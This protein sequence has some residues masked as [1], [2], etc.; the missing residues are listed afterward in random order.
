MVENED[1]NK[2]MKV[3]YDSSNK[4]NTSNKKKYV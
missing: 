2:K 4:I 3:E 1:K